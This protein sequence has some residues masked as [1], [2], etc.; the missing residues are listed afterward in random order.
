MSYACHVTRH[1]IGFLKILLDSN[2]EEL[3]HSLEAELTSTQP[4]SIDERINKSILNATLAIAKSLLKN[5]AVLL[6]DAHDSHILLRSYLN[7]HKTPTLTVSKRALHK[8]LIS[9]LQEHLECKTVEQS[10]GIILYRKGG[11]IMKSL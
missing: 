11:D 5:E 8:H 9:S 7:P 2:L 10:V 1:S 3:I 6:S 4:A